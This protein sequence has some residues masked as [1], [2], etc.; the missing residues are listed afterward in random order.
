MSLP[1]GDT[2][3]YSAAINALLPRGWAWPR[4][5]ESNLA[6]LVG[7]LAAGF[8][9]VHAAIERFLVVEADPRT[10][11]D[12]LPDWE[13]AFGLPDECVADAEMTLVE[14]HRALV[15]RIAARGGQSIA[16]LVGLAA[17][18]GYNI[19]IAEYR[20]ATCVDACDTPVYTDAWIFVFQVHAPEETVRWATC[21]DYCNVALRTWGNTRLECL[22]NRAK[23]AHTIALFAYS[24]ADLPFVLDA[25]AAGAPFGIVLSGGGDGDPSGT[26][27]SEGNP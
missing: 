9:R 12:L 16:Y 25:G 3:A 4:T 21:V 8:S 27:L 7:A 15:G 18:H 20:P 10:T 24:G 26:V 14:R 2:A 23:P 1:P 13:R 22:I 6:R 11:E 19:S 17:W 5:P